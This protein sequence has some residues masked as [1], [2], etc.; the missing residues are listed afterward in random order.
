[1]NSEYIAEIKFNGT[2][3]AEELNDDNIENLSAEIKTLFKK[4]NI[5]F[6]HYEFI[7]I[8]K[9][10]YS[11]DKCE[12]CGNYTCDRDKNPLGLGADLEC[13]FTYIYDGGIFDT[14]LLCEMCLPSEH[15][16]GV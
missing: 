4:Y 1:M 11:I 8:N 9:K 14:Q 10:K 15:R 3:E 2:L 13:F 5:T 16:W 7:S 12:K 6:N